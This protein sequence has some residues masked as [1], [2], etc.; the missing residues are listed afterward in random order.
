M[1]LNGAQSF[2]MWLT[3]PALAPSISVV[4]M[5]A[6]TVEMPTVASPEQRTALELAGAFWVDDTARPGQPGQS[7]FVVWTVDEAEAASVVAN[8]TGLTA[9]D[10][11][12]VHG[13]GFKTAYLVKV[14][15]PDM[16][17]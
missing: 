16:T 5:P 2:L 3:C 10:L 9:D 4:P 6:F 17:D 15:P 12:T 7:H 8:A 14:P 1:A 13:H 11:T